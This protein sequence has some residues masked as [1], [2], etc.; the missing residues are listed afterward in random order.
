M[1]MRGAQDRRVQGIPPYRQIVGETPGAAQQ[2]GV[3]ETADG[4]PRVG[5]RPVNFGR[6]F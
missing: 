2:V 3:L 1:G 5:H 6:R 4:T